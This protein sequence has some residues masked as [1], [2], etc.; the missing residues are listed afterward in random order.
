[1]ALLPWAG[2][3]LGLALHR[4]I[5]QQRPQGQHLL[6]IHRHSINSKTAGEAI[7]LPAPL[8]TDKKL[9]VFSINIFWIT[10]QLLI[11]KPLLNRLRL[12]KA[13]FDAGTGFF[14]TNQPGRRGSL[15]PTEHCIEG[16]QQQRLASSG[17]T[18]QHREARLEIQL[19]A[20]NQS[21]ILKSQTGQHGSPR[22]SC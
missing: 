17:F 21:N 20:V 6:T 4:E 8:A 18:R 7:V 15:H 2:Q 5:H 19:Q 1:M 12:R 9:V 14:T 22:W 16:I 3:L 13:S 11:L 10:A